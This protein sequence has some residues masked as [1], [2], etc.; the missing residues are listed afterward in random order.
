MYL[1]T[2]SISVKK[3]NSITFNVSEKNNFCQIQ[4]L[5][6]LDLINWNS[7]EFDFFR[8]YWR[9]LDL[10]PYIFEIPILL[11]IVVVLKFGQ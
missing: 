5:A 7:E 6:I 4:N 1:K 2:I 10:S 11:F 9:A 3:L 8:D